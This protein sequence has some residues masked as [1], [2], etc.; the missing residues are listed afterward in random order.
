MIQDCVLWGVRMHVGIVERLV[1]R[2]VWPSDGYG[3]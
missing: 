3:N 1:Y 2:W